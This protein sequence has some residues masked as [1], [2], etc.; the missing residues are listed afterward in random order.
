MASPI[1]HDD[2]ALE[3]ALR[4]ATLKCRFAE[5]IA[6]TKGDK[7]FPKKVQQEREKLVK[8]QSGKDAAKAAQK[9][10]ERKEEIQKKRELAR[11]ALEELERSVQGSFFDEMKELEK[12]TNS[13]PS[14]I[15]HGD[16]F[17]TVWIDLTSGTIVFEGLPSILEYKISNDDDDDDDPYLC[18][19]KKHGCEV[20]DQSWS[21]EKE[22]SKTL[23]PI[24]RFNSNKH[25][26]SNVF[27]SHK[28]VK[29]EAVSSDVE[30]GEIIDP[31]D[32]EPLIGC[33]YRHGCEILYQPWNCEGE[34]SEILDPVS[35]YGS[36]ELE[37]SNLLSHNR[38]EKAVSSDVE[39]G[40]IIDADDD[41]LLSHTKKD[42]EIELYPLSSCNNEDDGE[43]VE[44]SW[45]RECE[46]GEILDLVLSC[47]RHQRKTSNLFS[48]H[49]G[50]KVV[51][52]DVE[53]GEILD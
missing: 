26:M 7:T 20:L 40:E 27:S 46:E 18:C 10:V 28:G 5:L 52:S 6:K 50:E 35:S 45:S 14:Y 29:K 42:V 23:D 44:H 4:A 19:K 49:K 2:E 8:V 47:K 37:I 53:D 41:P 15:R 17:K 36:N 30:A 43:M 48:S 11:L 51:S 16:V 33:N 12:C 1:I 22:K 25:E 31:D 32:D 39:D 38:G 34:K 24:S 21:S 9:E 3:K 13:Y